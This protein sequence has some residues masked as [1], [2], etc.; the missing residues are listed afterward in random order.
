MK[1]VGSVAQRQKLFAGSGPIRWLGE[2]AIA[3]RQRLISAQ[4]QC[5]RSPARNC[6]RFFAREQRRHLRRIGGGTA[7]F[8]FPLVELGRFNL[9]GNFRCTQN[10]MPRLAFRRQH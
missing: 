8:N 1:L 7:A 5:P 9:V 6:E 2:T 10:G 4:N 3:D